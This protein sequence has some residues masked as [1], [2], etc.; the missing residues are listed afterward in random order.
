MTPV[1]FAVE[2]CVIVA[3]VAVSEVSGVVPPTAPVS[4]TVPLLPPVRERV[5]AP[6]IVVEKLMFAPAAV[7]PLFVVSTATA[8]VRATGPVKVVTPPLVVKLPFKLIA[9]GAV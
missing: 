2:L 4:V 8:V 1:V 6:L 5:C 3:P 9:V 7:P